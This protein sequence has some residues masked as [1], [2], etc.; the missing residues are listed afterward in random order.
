MPDCVLR[1]AGSKAK[2]KK[3]LAESSFTPVKVYY[4]GE[5]G[6]GKSRGPNKISGFHVSL[7]GFHGTSISKQASQAVKFITNRRS[8]F[9][10]LASYKFKRTSLDFGLYD[11]ASEERPWPSYRISRKLVELAGEFGLE[12]VLSF[13]GKP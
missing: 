9:T 7:S 13:Y 11:L 3:F 2:V 10:L 1:V 12:I 5:F 6:H 8:D 4:C